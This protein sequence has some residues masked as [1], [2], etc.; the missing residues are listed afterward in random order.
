MSTVS[1]EN[2][3]EQRDIPTEALELYRYAEGIREEFARGITYNPKNLEPD[4]V[5]TKT[6]EDQLMRAVEDSYAEA[7]KVR[8]YQGK[9]RM[10]TK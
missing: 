5:M 8:H 9:E 3:V 1:S 7:Y 10:S 6:P 2:F 4:F